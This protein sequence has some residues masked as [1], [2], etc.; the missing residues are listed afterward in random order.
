MP[1]LIVVGFGLRGVN[2]DANPFELDDNE[3]TQA[4]NVINSI[5]SG[6]SSIRKRAGLVSFTLEDTADT[7]LGGIDLPLQDLS[8]NGTHYL[9]IGRGPI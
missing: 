8:A 9:Y 2:V 6:S 1:K 7:V 5:D 4:Q 3:L